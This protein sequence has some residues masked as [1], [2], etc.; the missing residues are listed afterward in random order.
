MIVTDD[1][2]KQAIASD[3]RSIDIFLGIGFGIDNTAADDM[4][5][6][7]AG[8]LPMSS[9][10]QV[11]DAVYSLGRNLA[12][13]EG[14]G[15]PTDP[16][17]N[18]VVPPVDDSTTTIET[19]L[20][21]DVISGSDGSM[22]W[23]VSLSFGSVHESA[24]TVYSGGVVTTT[25]LFVS[26]SESGSWGHSVT[27]DAASGENIHIDQSHRYDTLRIQV[28]KIDKAYHHARIAEMEFGSSV[29][30]SNN[31]IR[32]E[33]RLVSEKD[34]TEQR[35]PLDEVTFEVINEGWIFDFDS[36]SR[37]NDSVSVGK[38]MLM[39]FRVRTSSG[40]RTIPCGKYY[41]RDIDMSEG[42]AR[43]TAD[44]PRAIMTDVME[45]WG[46][47]QATSIG[48]ATDTVCD[49]LLIAHL[50]DTSLYSM[51]P[52]RDLSF[53]SS[54]TCM[55]DVRNVLQRI[56]LEMHPQND[57]ILRFTTTVTPQSYGAVEESRMLSY[58]QKKTNLSTYNMVSVTY[59]EDRRQ[60][61]VSDLRTTSAASLNMLRVDNPLV[62]TEDE[63]KVI[64]DRIVANLYNSELDVEWRGDPALQVGDMVSFP[65]RFSDAT[66]RRVEYQ[67]LTFNGG[68]SARTSVVY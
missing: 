16:A 31:S 18:M 27:V 60:S 34:A 2:Y 49:S 14:D 40:Y 21:S 24:L 6:I 68:L 62:M 59:G 61:Y 57:G 44:D 52:P 37:E 8:L 54:S 23:T 25:K 11:T 19:A 53:G 20:W 48:E 4:T 3:L 12:T 65:G 47:P 67:E 13:F 30:L 28:L 7:T 32:G 15:I 45:E 50:C 63:A 29:T 9:R 33:V 17:E 56:G 10:A 66:P 5:G 26:L 42:S 55:E 38:P 51:Y 41:I 1:D 39:S 35:C 36:P 64:C 43:V 46:I 58:P 22:D